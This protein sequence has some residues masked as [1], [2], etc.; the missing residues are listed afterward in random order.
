MTCAC[1]ECY[2]LVCCLSLHV[3]LAPPHFNCARCGWHSPWYCSYCVQHSSAC[4][5]VAVAASLTCSTYNRYLSNSLLHCAIPAALQH[6]CRYGTGHL[7]SR[8]TS[9]ATL[10][11][12]IVTTNVNWVIQ[13]S[14]SLFGSMGYLFFLNWKLALVYVAI[15]GIFFCMTRWFGGIMRTLQRTIQVIDAC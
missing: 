7:T 3:H 14:I 2:S 4:C 11:G 6:R 5:E 1:S 12:T 8:L 13:T 10:L 15:A 9:D